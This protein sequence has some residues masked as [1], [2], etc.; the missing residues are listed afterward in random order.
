MEHPWLDFWNKTAET[1][2]IAAAFCFAGAGFLLW[3]AEE[4]HPP[5]RVVTVIIAGQITNAATTAFVHGYLG[6]SIFIAPLI[7]LV[8]GLTA[9]PLLMAVIR[10]GESNADGIIGAAIRKLT[11]QEPKA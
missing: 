10:G 2:G 8:C 1:L 5:K 11:G 3:V 4:K 7:G 6:W 9:V